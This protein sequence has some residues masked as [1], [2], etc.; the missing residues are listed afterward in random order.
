MTPLFLIDRPYRLDER[1]KGEQFRW[2]ISQLGD[3][4]NTSYFCDRTVDWRIR[5][6]FPPPVL[7]GSW[8]TLS[9]TH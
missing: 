2:T 5:G 1:E 6:R 4:Q 9:R 8:S 7:L 3:L